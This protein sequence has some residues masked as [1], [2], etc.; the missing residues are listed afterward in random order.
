MLAD[1]TDPTLTGGNAQLQRSELETAMEQVLPMLELGPEDMGPAVSS[2][3][4]LRMAELSLET[5]QRGLGQGGHTEKFISPDVV[6]VPSAIERSF[7]LDDPA[8]YEAAFPYIA[9]TYNELSQNMPADRAYVNAALSAT[10]YGSA[11]YFESYAGDLSARRAV[12]GDT[13][14]DDSPYY[15]SIADY[16]RVA[17]CVE[18][19]SVSHNTLLIL[20]VSSEYMNGALGV[21][22]EGGEFETEQHAFIVFPSPSG[23]KFIYDPTNPRVY[24]D[25][26]GQITGIQ[27]AFYR[28]DL[29]EQ[30]QQQVTLKEYTIVDGE[31]QESKATELIYTVPNG[32]SARDLT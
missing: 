26:T 11:V 8:A 20:G 7:L 19:A 17:F 18:R 32:S 24:R 30:G 4:E 28:L 9:S 23:Q 25:E 1:G 10:N 29:N 13:I 5:D 27:P 14:D 12:T 15:N 21:Q 22:A 6:M 16:K 31:P 2:Y 3:V